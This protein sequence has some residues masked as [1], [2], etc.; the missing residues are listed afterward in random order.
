MLLL[1]IMDKPI[2]VYVPFSTGMFF[3]RTNGERVDA[4][5]ELKWVASG[6]MM[7]MLLV[8]PA[9]CG[10]ISVVSKLVFALKW[11]ASVL[12]LRACSWTWE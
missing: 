2:V 3:R 10:L 6:R 4:R 11:F 8:S 7:E 9:R 1:V 5:P 12:I